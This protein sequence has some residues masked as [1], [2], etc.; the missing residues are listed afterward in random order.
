MKVE[1]DVLYLDAN[2]KVSSAVLR[3]SRSF[4]LECRVGQNTAFH[5]S[6]VFNSH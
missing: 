1:V 3:V 5:V 2:G 6:P 4:S